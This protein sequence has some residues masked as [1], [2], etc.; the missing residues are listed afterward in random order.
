MLKDL[1]H[2]VR[3]KLMKTRLRPIRVFVFHHVSEEIDPLIC[4]EEDWTQLDQFKQNIEKL[5]KQYTFISLSN[6]YDKL[7]H[8]RFRIK[9]Y[10]VLTSDDGLSSVL[11]ILTWLEEKGIPLTL[12]VN[13]CYMEGDKLKPVHE[14]WLREIVPDA[15]SKAIAKKM[16]LSKKQIWS[17]NSLLIEIGMHGHE[18]LDVQ[19]ISEIQFEQDIKTCISK[20][21]THPRYIPAYAFPWG[22]STKDAVTYLHRNN[23][24]PVVVHGGR[25]YNWTGAI[26]RECIDNK[27]L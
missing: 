22:K 17:L 1:I 2:R 5:S 14:K 19:L 15:D 18:H 9:R 21:K 11:N 6:A 12:F 3:R 4:K 26:D 13:T 23:I 10:A 8:D 20:L 7:Q 27:T 16:Y 25:N 24:I